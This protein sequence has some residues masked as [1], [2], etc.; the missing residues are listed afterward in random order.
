MLNDFAQTAVLDLAA[1]S[2]FSSSS[3][4]SFPFSSDVA[5]MQTRRMRNGRLARRRDRHSREEKAAYDD[6][7]DAPAPPYS[8]ISR[9]QSFSSRNDQPRKTYVMIAGRHLVRLRGR[10]LSFTKISR[11]TSESTRYE[12]SIGTLIVRKAV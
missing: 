11:G 12:N 8:P 5:P 10:D 2:S 9:T 6:P 3:P 7:D 4:L 1:F